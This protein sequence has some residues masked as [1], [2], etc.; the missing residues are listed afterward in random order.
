MDGGG[1]WFLMALAAAAFAC[2]LVKA[3]Y[4]L[5]MSSA[6]SISSASSA[7]SLSVFYFSLFCSM[8]L[9]ATGD[10]GSRGAIR[11]D[12]VW[13]YARMAAFAF[14]RVAFA[15]RWGSS[16][17]AGVG[18]VIYGYC[19]AISSIVLGGGVLFCMYDCSP[20]MSNSAFLTAVTMGVC[21]VAV[22]RFSI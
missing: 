8:F 9:F 14:R 17:G 7:F 13:I 1:G 19:V 3:T 6:L 10:L 4:R 11:W 16:V 18:L 20:A 15:G 12:S 21:A 2:S 22:S 5:R